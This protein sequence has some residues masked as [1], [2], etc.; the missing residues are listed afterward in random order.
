MLSIITKSLF[1]RHGRRAV[2]LYKNFTTIRS[3]TARFPGIK[4]SEIP[5]FFGIGSEMEIDG[6]DS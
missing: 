2:P 4:Q 6:F 5:E 3:G 1:V